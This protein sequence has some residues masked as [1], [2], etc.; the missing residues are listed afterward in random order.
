M[1]SLIWLLMFV[2][3]VTATPT[4]TFNPLNTRQKQV[5]ADVVLP[6]HRAKGICPDLIQLPRGPHS[7][8]PNGGVEIVCPRD[9]D[10]DRYDDDDD[11]WRH[12][13]P[14]FV[15]NGVNGTNA[16]CHSTHINSSCNA[17][18]CTG[19]MTPLVV[20]SG[21]QG[22]AGPV[23]PTGPCPTVTIQV[24]NSLCH[25]R[26][27]LV[28][29]CDARTPNV[30]C[31]PT[32]T[33]QCNCTNVAIPTNSSVCSGRG[34]VQLVCNGV[35]SGV[36]ICNPPRSTLLGCGGVIPF[37]TGPLFGCGLV[38]FPQ[39]PSLTRICVVADG[40]SISVLPVTNAA[41]Q[42]VAF[43]DRL[44][45]V[46]EMAYPFVTPQSG[47]IT[48]IS[49]RFYWTTCRTLPLATNRT[50]HA[51]IWHAPETSNIFTPLAGTDVVL[52]PNV[53]CNVTFGPAT[54][55]LL[56]GNL[57]NINVS[58]SART[59]L[60]LVLWVLT[61]NDT[62]A[63]VIGS[64]E[65]G[66]VLALSGPG[67]SAAAPDPPSPTCTAKLIGHVTACKG[68]PGLNLTCPGVPTQT[69]CTVS[70]SG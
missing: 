33:C 15:C 4:P 17:L 8:C 30:T 23:G 56:V 35:R 24:N 55:M 61:P 64:A 13:G 14:V 12:K 57:N 59:A 37:T 18:L 68:G 48:G 34:G 16:F 60:V 21:A 22:P 62:Y 67:C 63:Q 49:V 19:M 41:N 54:P 2:V 38:N 11:G 3:V 39:F 65:A 66:M 27:A 50:V 47:S 42:P 7:P 20:C 29:Q 25:G 26:A 46:S 40:T 58:V 44:L 1:P 9:N 28:V 51:E 36:P 70:S 10:D 53:S 43:D 45:T 69:V 6:C 5:C 31:L 32:P 52:H